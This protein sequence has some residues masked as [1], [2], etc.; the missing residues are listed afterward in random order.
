MLQIH[1]IQLAVVCT[2]IY[3]PLSNEMRRPWANINLERSCLCIFE[4]VILV[5]A[6]GF[7]R[8]QWK[9]QQD[10]YN[11]A[12]IQT[13]YLL[14]KNLECYNHT[15]LLSHNMILHDWSVFNPQVHVLIIHPKNPPIQYGN[16][17][18]GYSRNSMRSQPL[19]VVTAMNCYV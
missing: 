14:N 3:R 16:L 5:L 1:V 10:R 2:A 6:S 12:D 15:K 8:K 9:P 4:S 13:K 11:L 7:W 18:T 19:R 17:N